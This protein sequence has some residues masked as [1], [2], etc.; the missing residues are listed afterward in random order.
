VT[1]SEESRNE[2]STVLN[3]HKSALRAGGPK[4]SGL[5]CTKLLS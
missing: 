1:K 5:R 2:E 4:R 3:T